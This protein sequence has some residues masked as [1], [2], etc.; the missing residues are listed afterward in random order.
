MTRDR[1]FQARLRAWNAL[2]DRDRVI[3][4]SVR[5]D[6]LDYDGAARCH[7]CTARD[8]EAVIVRVLVALMEADDDA[9][10]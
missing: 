10:P 7:G 5:I 3:F 1:Q 9:P 6:G 2:P 4:A 8:V